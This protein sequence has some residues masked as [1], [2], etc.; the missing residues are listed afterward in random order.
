[1][2]KQIGGR[3]RQTEVEDILRASR[4]VGMRALSLNAVASR[5][6]VSAAALYRHVEGR[7]GLERLLGE[8]LLGELQLHDDPAHDPVQHLLSFGLQLR[9]HSIEHPGLVTYLQTLFPRGEGGRA[10]LSTEVEALVRR[11]Y[12]PD[13]AIVLA[14][15]VAS[16]TI[17]YAAA[18][19][20]Q[21]LHAKELDAQRTHA[22][23]GLLA[24]AHLHQPHS[25]L[26][27]IDSDSY[28]RLLLTAAIR[29]FVDIAPPGRDV[30]IFLAELRAI[31]QGI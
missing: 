15:A 11:G 25:V 5:L 27:Q 13:A 29:G 14:S 8:Q 7:W 31:G 19:E 24:D 6:D 26:P 10:L 1:M 28:V 30:E 18:E 21:Q 3:P 17:G 12:A 2:E 16:T 20:S 22:T 23:Q 9:E 4:A